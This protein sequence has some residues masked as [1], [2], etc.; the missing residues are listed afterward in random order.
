[1]NMQ[2]RMLEHIKSLTEQERLLFC[3][4]QLAI[5]IKEFRV[6]EKSMMTEMNYSG[7]HINRTANNRGGRLTTV[8]AKAMNDTQA[9]LASIDYLKMIVRHL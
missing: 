4:K 2:D 7:S 6:K 8:A 1:M 9:Y 3:R 5:V